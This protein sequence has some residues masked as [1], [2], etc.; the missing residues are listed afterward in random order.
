[1]SSSFKTVLIQESAIADLTPEETFAV[2]SGGAEKTLQKFLATSASNNSLIWNI[3]VPSESVV[4][5]R[6]PLL[7]SDIN[8]TIN[9]TNPVVFT[10]F[11]GC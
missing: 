7:Q 4:V 1:M 6:H 3:Q 10:G 11:V 5:S 2:Y 8:F 9:I